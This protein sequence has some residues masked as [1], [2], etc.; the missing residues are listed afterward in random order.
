ML[1]YSI[2]IPVYNA[3]NTIERC[4]E[5]IISNKG[6]IFEIILIDDCSKDNSLELCRKL[7]K[8]YENVKCLS[9]ERNR[10]VSFTRNRGIEQARGKYTLFID[11]D[12]WIEEDYILRFQEVIDLYH[13]LMAVCGFVN[14]DEKNNGIREVYDWDDFEGISKRSLKE[15]IKKLHD[16]TLLQQLWNK[17]FV[18]HI[19]K[20]KKICFDENINIGEDLRFILEYIKVSQIKDIILINRPL[21][22]YMRDQEGSLMY[23]VGYESVEEPLKNLKALYEIMELDEDDIK[24]KLE[25]DR[26]QQIELYAYLIFHNVGMKRREK[27]RLI[28][29]LDKNKGKFLYR[30]NQILYYKERIAKIFKSMNYRRKKKIDD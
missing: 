22:H 21:Y 2:I 25:Q 17:V 15:E 11:S 18:T 1:E 3:A 9:N 28:L 10:G 5:S 23:K 4:V 6:M 20:E 30:N 12:D 29:A 27:K 13:P 7:E 26:S 19:I 16:K 8:K 14:H 24:R